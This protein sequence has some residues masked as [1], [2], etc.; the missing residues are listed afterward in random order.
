MPRRNHSKLLVAAQGA[1]Y[2]DRLGALPRCQVP[3]TVAF[4]TLAHTDAIVCGV[5]VGN[6]GIA[7]KTARDEG[8][9]RSGQTIVI[10]AGMPF[11]TA[12]TT[13]LLRIATLE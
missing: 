4:F 6:D 5:C 10:A 12:G 2:F 9:A 13:N 8:L 1:P 11:G 7:C 3:D